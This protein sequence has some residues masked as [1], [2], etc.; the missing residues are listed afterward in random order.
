ML[1]VLVVQKNH[2]LPV[3]WCT[4]NTYLSIPALQPQRWTAPKVIHLLSVETVAASTL[5]LTVFYWVALAGGRV[6][7]DNIMKHGA[8]NGVIL[9]DILLSRVPF[10]SYHF[11][12]RPC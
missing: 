2:F 9:V 6:T 12:V 1:P 7:G 4:L 5:F 8:N 11:Q 3:A 10:A